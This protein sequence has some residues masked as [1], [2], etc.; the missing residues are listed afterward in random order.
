[1]LR[2][3]QIKQKSFMRVAGGGRK[4]HLVLSKLLYIMQNA[5]LIAKI[6]IILKL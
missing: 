3:A 6:E 2:A 5:F 1:M 4:W